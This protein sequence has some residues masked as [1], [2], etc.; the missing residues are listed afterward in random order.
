MKIVNREARTI[1]YRLNLLGIRVS[2]DGAQLIA[3]WRG[4][5]WATIGP[6]RELPIRFPLTPS[7]LNGVAGDTLRL[8][9]Y[10]YDAERPGSDLR[11]VLALE[12]E[13]DAAVEVGM[14]AG[15]TPA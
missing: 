12:K 11:A 13:F 10:Q 1:D 14:A 6:R 4:D 9:A 7:D 15:L 8:T 5:E 2:K 3:K